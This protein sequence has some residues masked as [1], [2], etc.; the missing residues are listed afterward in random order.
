MFKLSSSLRMFEQISKPNKIEG[1]NLYT[2]KSYMR[3]N[4]DLQFRDSWL[5]Y[6]YNKS[7]IAIYGYMVIFATLSWKTQNSIVKPKIR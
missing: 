6:F 5:T 3:F 7:N 2:I 4:L 1:N